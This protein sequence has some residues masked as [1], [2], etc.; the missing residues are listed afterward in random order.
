MLYPVLVSWVFELQTN[1]LVVLRLVDLFVALL[2]SI[3]FIRMLRNV[4]GGY[5]SACLLGFIFLFTLN[6]PLFIQA[7]F[8]NSMF[9]AL[10]PLSFSV[11]LIQERGARDALVW[12]ITGALVALSVLLR[13]TFFPFALLGALSV[14]VGY[15]FKR[16]LAFSVAG[17][18]SGLLMLLAVILLRGGWRELFEGYSTAGDLYAAISSQRTQLFMSNGGLFVRESC[19]ALILGLL[20]LAFLVVF[21]FSRKSEGGQEFFFWC[22]V[23]AVPLFEPVFKIGFPYHFSMCLVGAAG[24]SALAWRYLSSQVSRMVS[25]VLPLGLVAMLLPKFFSLVGLGLATSANVG[26]GSKLDWQPDVIQRSNY[27]IAADAIRENSKPGDTLSVSGF[28]Y[29]LFPLTGLLPPDGEVAHLTSLITK[30]GF[31]EHRF[32]EVLEA[33]PP[34]VLMTTTR[35]DW[36][37]GN[38]IAHA[39]ETSGLYRRVA[40]IDESPS[41][42]YGRFGGTIYRYSGVGDG[43]RRC[44]E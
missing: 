24:L 21:Y 31:D 10:V 11:L 2:A 16:F 27:L 13:E 6:Q 40:T 35:V 37:G 33:C 23:T 12:P 5:I 19:A 32:I 17:L 29:T 4:S 15:G 41:R 42:S 8:K 22:A 38:E 20:S 18:V 26:D 7:G 43:G 39:V 3:F 34:D 1:H 30:L 14:L 44:A 36:P 9:A 28:M 25:Y